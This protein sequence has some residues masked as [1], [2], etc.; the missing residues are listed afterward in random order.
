MHSSHPKHLLILMCL[1]LPLITYRSHGFRVLTTEYKFLILV[2]VQLVGSLSDMILHSILLFLC[3]LLPCSVHGQVGTCTVQ[4][5][6]DFLQQLSR[7]CT[8]G[9]TS[10]EMRRS[11][12]ASQELFVPSTSMLDAVCH[13][14]CGGAY[15]EW[16]RVQCDDPYTAR[17]VEAMCIFTADTASVGTRCRYAFPDAVDNLRGAFARVFSCG[18]GESSVCLQISYECSDRRHRL[19]LSIP[20]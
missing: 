17:M 2:S 18:V 6:A 20:L 3:V 14:S 5:K 13:E 11:P 9:L 19:L 15:A 10:L 7:E 12:Q 16:L 1:H 8:T 4:N